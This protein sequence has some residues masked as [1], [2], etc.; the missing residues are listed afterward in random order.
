PHHLAGLFVGGD[1]PRCDAG[2][3]YDEIAPQGGAA[4]A[5]LALLL[6]VHPPN[7]AA[8]I[9]GSAVDLIE[10]APGIRNVEEAVFRKRRRHRIF[11]AG[12]AAEGHRVSKLEILHVVAIDAGERPRELA[13]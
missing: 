11:V 6:G 12:A 13:D 7:D 4:I 10:H 2:T 1:D 8:D 9:A 5:L 3:G